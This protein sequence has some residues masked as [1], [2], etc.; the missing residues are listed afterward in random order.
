MQKVKL[1]VDGARL[2]KAKTGEQQS[3]EKQAREEKEEEPH[4]QRFMFLLGSVF[5]LQS[6]D[7]KLQHQSPSVFTLIKE[8]LSA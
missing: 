1:S 8:I 7:R 2:S 5:S 6:S 3:W 4:Q